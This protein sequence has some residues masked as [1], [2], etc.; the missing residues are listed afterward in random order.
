VSIDDGDAYYVQYEI[1]AF[2]QRTVGPFPNVEEARM[3]ALDI[4]G[5]EGVESVELLVR[6]ADGTERP[7]P[8]RATRV[9]T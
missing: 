5:Y 7:I 2:G 8:T 3:Q 9:E 6:S 1:A 4:A